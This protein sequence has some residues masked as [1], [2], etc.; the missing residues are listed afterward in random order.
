MSELKRADSLICPSIFVMEKFIER[1]VPE[2]LLIFNP[3][4]LVKSQKQE[5]KSKGLSK[6]DTFCFGYLGQIK[7]HKGVHLL[8]DAFETNFK[9]EKKTKLVIHGKMGDDQSYSDLIHHMA[10]K[11]PAIQLTGEYNPGQV[12]KLLSE[13]DVLVI[14]LLPGMKSDRWFCM[15]HFNQMFR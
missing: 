13:I 8:I 4:G 11:N 9:C 10:Q 5:F 15:K 12:M 2:D 6:D 1:G 14:S 3:H 7:Y